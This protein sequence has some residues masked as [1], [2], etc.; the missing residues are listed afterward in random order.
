[1][2]TW[3]RQVRYCSC[4]N[5]GL[6]LASLTFLLSVLLHMR[7][8]VKVGYL[9]CWTQLVVKASNQTKMVFA[10][11]CNQCEHEIKFVSICRVLVW[12]CEV[13]ASTGVGIV[14]RILFLLCW[15]ACMFLYSNVLWKTKTIECYCLDFSLYV[16]ASPTSLTTRISSSH[17]FIMWDAVFYLSWTLINFWNLS[18]EQ[19]SLLHWSRKASLIE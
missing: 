6:S 5:F 19:W 14:G 3:C 2:P 17:P 12:Y 18:N 16:F 15:S 11:A 9:L 13:F 7:L 4:E 10:R 8:S 1:M